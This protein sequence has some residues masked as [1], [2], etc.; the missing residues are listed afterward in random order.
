V[1]ANLERAVAE[2]Y[3]LRPQTDSKTD[4]PL[5][6]YMQRTRL[7]EEV[8]RRRRHKAAVVEPF[9][10]DEGPFTDAGTRPTKRQ[11]RY[12]RKVAAA[13]HMRRCWVKDEAAANLD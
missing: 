9:D 13:F 4:D 7:V 2:E 8:A 6:L 10:E 1:V 5:Q 11:R 3:N 12:R